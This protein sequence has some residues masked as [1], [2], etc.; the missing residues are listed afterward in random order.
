[1]S[2]TPLHADAALLRVSGLCTHYQTRARGAACVRAVDDVSFTLHR[3]RTLGIVG[4]SGCGKTTL[5]R[6]ILRLIP[7]SGGCVE[8]DGR[9]VLA[10]SG[11]DL[12]AMRREMQI[13]FQDPAGSL[14]AHHRVESLVGEALS[15]H[16][17]VRSR[18][19]RR[20]RVAR[21][22]EQV[23]LSA[24]AIGRYP[25]EFSGGQRQRIAIA[26][27]L[28]LGPKLLIC[29]EPVSA[30][31][32]SIQSQILNLLLDLR[33][34][35]ELSY[36]FISHD[37]AVVRRFCDEVAVMYLGRIVEQAPASEL[38]ADPRHPYTRAL[39][40]AAPRG[41]PVRRGA[42]P[43]L[44]GEPPSPIDVPAGCAFTPRCPLVALRCHA[45]RPAL[46]PHAQADRTH[47]VACHH[48][49]RAEQ[50]R[51]SEPRR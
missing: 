34:K 4:E 25:H 28:A 41:D 7:A 18:A 21:L 32:V 15:V 44:S 24:E 9:D 36:L 10:L 27:A 46:L 30:L 47:I 12:R 22:L 48:A 37:L 11:P 38:F 31:D 42:L 26:R 17:M 3:G 49:D 39:L 40:A 45:E 50:P 23:G 2:D 43:I 16:G 33:D 20:E 13:V 1:M 51:P 19:Q 35:L 29:D 6:T 8:F 5:A 14:N